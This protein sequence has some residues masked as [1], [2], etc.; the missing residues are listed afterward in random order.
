LSGEHERAERV[1]ADFDACSAKASVVH[2]GPPDV[3][4]RCADAFVDVHCH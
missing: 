1:R 4:E 3:S 2:K